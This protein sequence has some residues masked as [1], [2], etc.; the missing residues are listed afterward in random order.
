M[1]S[2]FAAIAVVVSVATTY[3][4]TPTPA[5]GTVSVL[6]TEAAP[7]TVATTASPAP[8]TVVASPSCCET[9]KEVRLTQW[10]AR[11][12]ARQAERQEARDCR[13]CC[14]G[15]CDCNDECKPTALVFTRARP[16]CTCCQK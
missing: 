5:D 14:K 3:A 9:A 4:D 15:K 2:I 12:L 7:A 6:K 11:R 13:D 1:R 16:A 8:A 10:Q